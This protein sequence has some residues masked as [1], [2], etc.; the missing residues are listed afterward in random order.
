VSHFLN[1]ICWHKLS[2]SI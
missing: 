2:I 1:G